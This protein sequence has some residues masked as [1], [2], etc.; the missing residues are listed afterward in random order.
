MKRLF[1]DHPA[2]V[3][4]SYAAH[5]VHAAGFAVLLG[6]AAF[7]CLIHAVLPALFEHRASRIVAKL[8][9]RMVM[10]RTGRS[11]TAAAL[12]GVEESDCNMAH[13]ATH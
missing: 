6:Y 1:L 7:A 8:H 4:E 9:V 2:S 5:F 12:P 11:E 10:K 13:G 3:G